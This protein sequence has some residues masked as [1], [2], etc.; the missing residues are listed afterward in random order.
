MDFAYFLAGKK[1]R[2]ERLSKE[3]RIWVRFQTMVLRPS[4]LLIS[5][6]MRKVRSNSIS[7]AVLD[8]SISKNL[9]RAVAQPLH[10]GF[11]SSRRVRRI[12]QLCLSMLP[13]GT[14]KGLDIGCGSGEIA[15]LM[16]GQRENLIM[17]GT[18]LLV[19]EKTAICVIENDGSS[20]PFADGAYDFSMLIDV[21][22]HTDSPSAVLA[23]ALRVSKS[24]LI[25]KDHFCETELDR[26]FLKF[27]DWA[28]NRAYDVR[29]PFN[30]LSR[31]EWASV[32]KDNKV[33]VEKQ[34]EKLGLY[35]QPLSLLFDRNLHF[36]CSLSR[37]N[38]RAE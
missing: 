35:W 34:I 38:E 9:A 24:F 3:I 20:L 1:Q 11:V 25:I 13:E 26:L 22:H 8:D 4:S 28:G 6:K 30:Y 5:A 33:I 32:Y 16:Q 23:E 12:S 21:L 17:E 27:M 10:K 2:K 36:I 19:R 18:D 14:L 29:M 31:E 37:M 15:A 7:F